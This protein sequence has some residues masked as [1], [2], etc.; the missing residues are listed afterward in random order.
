VGHRLINAQA[1]ELVAGELEGALPIRQVL[2]P[3][4][5]DQGA[6][7]RVN[8]QL[9]IRPKQMAGDKGYAFRLWL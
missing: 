1:V 2:R 7:R 8:G 3:H 6:I 9:R 4:P 5:V